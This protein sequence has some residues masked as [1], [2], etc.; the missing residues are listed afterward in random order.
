M[1]PGSESIVGGY[2]CF[3]LGAKW[4]P[5]TGVMFQHPWRG[6]GDRYGA[7]QLSALILIVSEASVVRPSPPIWVLKNQHMLESR[8]ENLYALVNQ[9]YG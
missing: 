7:E 3:D 1:N 2:R 4:C 8:R 9:S 6:V 5:T